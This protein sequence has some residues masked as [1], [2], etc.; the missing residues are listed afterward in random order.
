MRIDR[1]RAPMAEINV[2]PLVDVTLVLLIIFMVTAPMLE[3]GI[4]ITLPK[5]RASQQSAP[6]PLAITLTREGVMYF[7]GAAVRLDE[8]RGQLTALGGGKPLVIRCDRHA[9]VQD[10]IAL[11]ELCRTTGFSD[12]H[13]A[14]MTDEE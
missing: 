1:A 5:V 14:T 6:A 10:L 8:L 12:I 4:P 9:F 7:Q 11:W 2:T 3:Q 13:I